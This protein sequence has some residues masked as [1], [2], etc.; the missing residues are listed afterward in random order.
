VTQVRPAGVADVAAVARL[1][2]TC[3]G[4]DAWSEVLVREG[5]T[6]ALPTVS[7]L[8]A[9]EEGEVV[10][11]AVTSSAGDIAE[12]QRIAVA[13]EHRRRGVGALLLAAAVDAAARTEADRMLLEVR[14]DN[15]PALAFY[16]GAG[17]VEIDRRERYYADGAPAIVLRLPLGKGCGGS[18]ASAG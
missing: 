14:A 3:L 8:V 11:H 5:V 2:S 9:V 18:S 16:A 13:G 10:G 6:G 7:Y 15:R 12:L 1:E 4:G 17:F